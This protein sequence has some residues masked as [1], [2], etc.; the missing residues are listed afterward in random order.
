[1]DI[2]D[3][4]SV[5]SSKL[6][7]QY[8]HGDS[9]ALDSSRMLD[10]KNLFNRV[11]ISDDLERGWKDYHTILMETKEYP[12]I[13]ITDIPLKNSNTYVFQKIFIENRNQVI[14]SISDFS[15]KEYLE[16]Y[17]D[18]GISYMML[19][20]VKIEQ[21]NNVLSMASEFVFHRKWEKK[22]RK[23]MD[24]ELEKLKS[25]MK[26][27]KKDLEYSMKIVEDLMNKEL[28]NSNEKDISCNSIEEISLIDHDEGIKRMGGDEELYKELLDGF[29]K[30]YKETTPRMKEAL[31]DMNLKE[32]TALAHGAKGAAGNIS[33]K[34]LFDIAKE[35]E[36]IARDGGSTLELY[37]LIMKFEKAFDDLCTCVNNLF[38][39]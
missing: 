15:K 38:K 6:T 5:F 26:E 29:C 39:K 8:I 9:P 16:N 12:D 4:I 3:K 33:A 24:E 1:M 27:I 18:L 20:P 32:L 35:L 30:Y 11:Y 10:L 37:I 19:E 17:I 25:E 14:I 28:V 7:V 21:F 34:Y 31:D 13:L 23:E 22:R 36:C 2:I